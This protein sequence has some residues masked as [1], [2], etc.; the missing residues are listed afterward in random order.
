MIHSFVDYQASKMQALTHF[1]RYDDAQRE[2]SKARLWDLFDGTRESLNMAHECVDRHRGKGIAGRIAK[3]NGEDESFTFDELSDWSSRIA[4]WLAAQGVTK[5]D[6]VAIM[7][8]PS[9]GFYACLFGAMKSGAI[10]VPLFTLFGPDGVR[11]RVED[12]KPCLLIAPDDKLALAG[13]GCDARVVNIYKVMDQSARLSSVFSPVTSSSDM[14]LFQY[15]S[16][17][18]R[19][20]PDAIKHAHRAVVTVGVAALYGT[21]VRPGDR[22]M[23]PSSPAWGH[24]LAHGTLGPLG[25]GV[26]IASYAGPFDAVR[27]L[28]ALDEYEITNLSAAAT[29]YRM[30]RQ[31][32]AANDFNFQLQKLSFTG[33]PLDSETAEW[34]EETFGQRV[35][36]MYG[37]T[38]VGVIL[39]QYPGADDLPAKNGSLGRPMPGL[40]VAVLNEKDEPCAPLEV[41]EIKV[42][43]RDGW[44]ATKDRGHTDAD[45]HFYHD[46]RADDVIISAGWTIS[47]KEVEDCLLRY[48]G[49]KDVAVIGTPDATRGQV[50]TAFVVAGVRVE[51]QA[52]QDFVRQNLAAHEYPRRVSFV[53]ELPKTPAGK[54]NRR[55]VRETYRAQ[56]FETHW[57][58]RARPIRTRDDP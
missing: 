40:A 22:F 17:T 32:G 57:P 38:E 56:T 53:D 20:L 48:E 7:L 34:A 39:S 24:G 2:F 54:I 35:R 43:R 46:G 14:G 12:C 27:L 37:T 28:R 15:T 52:L 19:E 26:S 1:T 25:L 49:V 44:F 4:N 21:G 30:M 55:A 9:L 33:E 16:G 6:R 51:A 50:V 41:G 29:H 3:A 5:G 31:S 45:G 36:S 47:A 11:L 42:A 8:E 23:C 58:T 10:A 13:I 18:T